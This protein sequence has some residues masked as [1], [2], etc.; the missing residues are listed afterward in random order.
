MQLK[1]ELLLLE[2]RSNLIELQYYGYIIYS[3]KNKNI[4]TFGNTGRYPFFH[5]SCAKPLQAAIIQELKTKEKFNLT[6]KEIAVCCASHT[7]E[8][9]HIELLNRVLQ[10][11]G[12]CEDD[13]Q[14]PA[15]EPLSKEEQK[16]LKSFSPL[17]NNCSGKHIL[18]LAVCKQIGWDTKTYLNP[19]Q[20]LQKLI[21]SKI[22]QLCE[23]TK[24]LP[25]T[26]DGCTAP[27]P[28]TSLEELT[29]GF[30]NVF[31]TE[32]YNDIKTAF[33]NN[34]YL[35]G[36]KGR[37]DTQIMQMN[38]TLAA[39]AGAGGLL[40]VVNTKTNEVLTFKIFDADM[41]ARSIIA[42]NVMLQLNWLNINSIY[43]KL[44]DFGLNNNVTT[45]TGETIGEYILN[46]DVLNWL[47]T[48]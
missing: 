13:L 23:T 21:Y 25:T 10:K 37:P 38:H 27:N 7:G 30:Y 2:T 26:K 4:K 48:L 17:H 40:V 9:V 18:M 32:K 12:L 14:C 8:P 33:I 41:K 44:L 29:T 43:S 5:R 15:I 39:K 35:I 19:A 47:E 34:P 1:P 3:D 36:G 46:K 31:C 22:K 16:R 28:A 45:E 11:T 24:E 6:D 42:I 20:P